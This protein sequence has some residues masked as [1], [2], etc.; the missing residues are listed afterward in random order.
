ML[1]NIH[2]LHGLVFAEAASSYLAGA[3]GRP[4][5]HALLEDLSKRAAS[6]SQ[7]LESLLRDAIGAD[8]QLA[9][10]VDPARLASLFDPAAAAEPARR[11]AEAQLHGLRL[12]M[13]A[14]DAAQ[15]FQE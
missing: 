14:L 5:A 1:R 2:A 4:R 11:L 10:H 12:S 9:A 6:G 13:G 7:D 3:I 8:P 15:P